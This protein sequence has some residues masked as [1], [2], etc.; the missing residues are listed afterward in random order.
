[1]RGGPYSHTISNYAVLSKEGIS[2]AASTTDCHDQSDDLSHAR[3]E[4]VC[5]ATDVHAREC[6]GEGGCRRVLHEALQR[7]SPRISGARGHRQC[8]GTS[9]ASLAVSLGRTALSLFRVP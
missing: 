2:H 3:A 9:P 6:R 7:V 4:G 8:P 5:P 1:M